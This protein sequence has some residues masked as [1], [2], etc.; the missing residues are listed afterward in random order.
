VSLD[1]A[2]LAVANNTFQPTSRLVDRITFSGIDARGGSQID[3]S[4]NVI[5]LPPAGRKTKTS[6]SDNRCGG[7]SVSQIELTNRSALCITGNR[8]R[9]ASPALANA[10]LY[11]VRRVGTG[12]GVSRVGI[13]RGSRLT[14]A[15]NDVRGIALTIGEGIHL[16]AEGTGGGAASVDLA[17]EWAV[18]TSLS[19]DLSGAFDEVAVSQLPGA[20][21]VALTLPAE[22]DVTGR[23]YPDVLALSASYGG[24]IAIRSRR[25]RRHSRR[26]GPPVCG[27]RVAAGGADAEPEV[28]ER[29]RRG[30]H[31]TIRCCGSFESDVAGHAVADDLAPALPRFTVAGLQRSVRLG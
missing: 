8:L 29:F 17:P 18:D 10:A 11:S 1:N 5:H 16:D 9:G 12:I 21:N 15:R 28:H 24:S 30:R 6:K 31:T 26:A 2:T 22:G 14:V 20:E 23:F 3:I 19:V 13:G 4:A 25:R 27:P 7:L